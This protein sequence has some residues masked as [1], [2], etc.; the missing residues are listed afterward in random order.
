MAHQIARG[1]GNKRCQIIMALRHAT[2]THPCGHL[3]TN[4]AVDK[5]AGTGIDWQS[6]QLRRFGSSGM[7]ERTYIN[8]YNEDHN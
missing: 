4:S 1:G 6:Y 5:E 7:D 3:K 2:T 8:A